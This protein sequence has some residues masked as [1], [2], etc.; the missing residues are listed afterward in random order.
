MATFDLGL[1][2]HFAVIFPFLLVWVITFVALSSTKKFGEDKNLHAIIGLAIAF[3]FVLSKDAVAMLNF[4]SPW[5]VIFFVFLI[6]I[7]LAFKLAGASDSD[8]SGAMKTKQGQQIVTWIIVISLLIIIISFSNVIGQRLLNEQFE[9]GEMEIS[10]GGDDVG[11]G[12]GSTDHQTNVVETI[13]HP[14]VL[15]L[16]VIL[17]IASFTIKQLSTVPS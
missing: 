2:D 17:L 3:I 6:F 10:E 11:E 1:F 7:I 14:K 12:V 16:L 15:A 5:F 4:A 8:I 9:E 13:F